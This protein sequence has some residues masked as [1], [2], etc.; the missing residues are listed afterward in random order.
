VVKEFK[1]KKAVLKSDADLI[2]MG[3]GTEN[4]ITITK[5]E[6]GNNIY[7]ISINIKGASAVVMEKDFIDALKFIGI[8][9]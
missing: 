7:C 2:A 3:C 5:D 1:M 8:M 6:I 9:E 4:K